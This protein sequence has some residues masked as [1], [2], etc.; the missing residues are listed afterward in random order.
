[1]RLAID[2]GSAANVLKLALLSGRGHF[3]V[4]PFSTSSSSS[5]FKTAMMRTKEKTKMKKAASWQPFCRIK[6]IF[7]TATGSTV[8]STVTDDDRNERTGER[9]DGGR[10]RVGKIFLPK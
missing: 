2:G 9:M 1:M 8:A 3:R 10:K 5:S 4:L 7:L 6:Q